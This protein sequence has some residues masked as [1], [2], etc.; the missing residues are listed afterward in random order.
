MSNR[1]RLR[2]ALLAITFLVG[3]TPAFAKE[4]IVNVTWDSRGVFRGELPIAKG[5]FKEACVD[6]KQGDRVRWSF[7]ADAGTSF[8]I[9]YHEGE[10]VTYPAKKENVAADEGVLDVAVTQGYCWMWRAPNQPAKV[11]MTL[12]KSAR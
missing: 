2:Q 12:E 1:L 7:R 5:K 8:N 11:E 6:L 9:H 3:I 10:K 4:H